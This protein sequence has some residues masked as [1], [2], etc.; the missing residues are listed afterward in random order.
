MSDDQIVKQCKPLLKS[1]P[2]NVRKACVYIF[3]VKN[4]AG[5]FGLICGIINDGNSVDTQ[6]KIMDHFKDSGMEF[7]ASNSISVDGDKKRHTEDERRSL[8]RLHST[9]CAEWVEN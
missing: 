5:R 1:L 8:R 3:I 4:Y 2:P 7:C 9:I 6:Q